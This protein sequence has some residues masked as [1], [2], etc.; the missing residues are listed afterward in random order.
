MYNVYA[1]VRGEPSFRTI[2]N[3]PRPLLVLCIITEQP[4]GKKIITRPARG[5][6]NNV[7]NARNKIKRLWKLPMGHVGTWNRSTSIALNHYAVASVVVCN[8]WI[9]KTEFPHSSPSSIEVADRVACEWEACKGKSMLLCWVGVNCFCV[10]P[11]AGSPG[12]K[13]PMWGLELVTFRSTSKAVDHY[14]VVAA[15]TVLNGSWESP[16]PT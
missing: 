2:L 8:L 10:L 9:C 13:L 3:P 12:W 14:T 15:C 7:C 5:I 6:R 4:L 11:V 1:R 16:L